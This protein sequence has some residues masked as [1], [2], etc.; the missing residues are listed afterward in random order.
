MAGVDIAPPRA[1]ALLPTRAAVSESA[2]AVDVAAPTLADA[3][4]PHPLAAG[5]E[6]T[7]QRPESP[8]EVRGLIERLDLAGA[9]SNSGGGD[10][11]GSAAASGGGA[12]CAECGIHSVALRRCTRCLDVAYCGK[13]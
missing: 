12:A 10:G 2:T 13:K 7:P 9:A 3:P 6:T 11:G 1:P 5:A 4:P 8:E